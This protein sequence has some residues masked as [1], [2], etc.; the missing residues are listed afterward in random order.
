MKKSGLR[1]FVKSVYQEMESRN[2]RSGTALE[3]FKDK[4]GDLFTGAYVDEKG[5]TESVFP[6]AERVLKMSIFHKNDF[7]SKTAFEKARR[8]L[9][10]SYVKRLSA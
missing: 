9:I 1:D 2:L 10:S 4:D 8:D 5:A 6:G 3:I 7:D